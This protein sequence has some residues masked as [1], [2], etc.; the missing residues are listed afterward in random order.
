MVHNLPENF[1]ISDFDVFHSALV[2]VP[3]S[4]SPGIA[5]ILLRVVA[6]FPGFSVFISET[7]FFKKPAA[8]FLY[9]VSNSDFIL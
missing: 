3:S 1:N 4:Q 2:N 9:L 6:A 7:H 5:P 8:A